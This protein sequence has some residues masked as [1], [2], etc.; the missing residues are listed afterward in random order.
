MVRCLNVAE[1]PSVA[2]AIS[3]VESSVL[4]ELFLVLF[5]QILGAGAVHRVMSSF[6]F[7]FFGIKCLEA[8]PRKVPVQPNFRV[9]VSN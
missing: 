5:F 3:E 7:I 6:L 4:K 1:K 8:A 2:K 9:Q